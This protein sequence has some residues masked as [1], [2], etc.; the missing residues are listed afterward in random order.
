MKINKSAILAL[1]L[2][3][4]FVVTNTALAAEEN[5]AP[6]SEAASVAENSIGGK[7][8]TRTRI[9]DSW[10]T[11]HSFRRKR[12]GWFRIKWRGAWVRNQWRWRTRRFNSSSTYKWGRNNRR[13][14]F[15]SCWSII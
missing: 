7:R 1:A 2:S 11:N 3:M 10:T 14:I 15:E 9:W 4:S 12:R 6:A 5:V 13:R 8:F